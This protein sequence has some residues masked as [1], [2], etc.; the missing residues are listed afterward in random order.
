MPGP[1]SETSATQAAPTDPDTDAST[2]SPPRPAA[3]RAVAEPDPDREA[4]ARL[5]GLG[6]TLVT[7]VLETFGSADAFREAALEGDLERIGTVPGL[8]EKRAVE[9]VHAVRGTL[10]ADFLG[11]ER[12]VRVFDAVRDRI[13]ARAATTPGKRHLRLL[14]PL[15]DR[16]AREAAVQEALAAAEEVQGLDLDTARQALAKLAPLGDPRPAYEGTVTIFVDTPDDREALRDAGI[17]RWAAIASAR[18]HE[19][20][21]NTEA[22]VYAYSD[23]GSPLMEA[24]HALSV[25][26]S[27]DPA[28]VVPWSETTRFEKARTALQAA[29]TLSDLRDR[30]SPARE[31]LA[32]LDAMV[33]DKTDV[34]PRQLPTLIQD[35]YDDAIAEAETRLGELTLTG[36]DLVAALSDRAPDA[37]RQLYVDAMDKATERIRAETGLHLDAFTETVPPEIDEKA[38]RGAQRDLQG[39]G[40]VRRLEAQ[41]KAAEALVKLRAGVIEEIEDHFAFDARQALGAF[42]A[43]HRL[44][45]PEWGD[46]LRLRAALHLDHPDGE[47]VDYRL[48]TDDEGKADPVRMALLTGAN[49]GGKTTLL[50]TIAQV[51]TM[52]H[53]GLPVPAAHAT[54]PELDAVH[55]FAQKR[56]LSAGAF[57]DFLVRF[58]PLARAEGRVFVL[59]D[60]VEAMTELEAA[61]EIIAS[62]LEDLAARDAFALFVTHMGP[63]VLPL[64]P[65]DVR[66]DG[67][68]ATGLDDEDRLVVSRSPR[69]GA[70]ARSTPELILTRLSRQGPEELREAFATLADR[71]RARMDEARGMR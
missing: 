16:S 6:P 9:L 26:F 46:G 41:A 47:P 48:G 33:D 62:F 24:D 4:L 7:R 29:A 58:F 49:S 64:V 57:E 52:A 25:P 15:P 21:R 8:S 28:V 67:I 23:G 51:L 36:K 12:V 45:A 2:E 35:I 32:V 38:V 31:A 3:D 69:I 17:D 63:H 65:D 68:E 55:F 59:A 30:P 54:V 39:K 5:P 40:A 19:R 66:V 50:E 37:V 27:T 18:D 43:D 70:L 1:T 53:A 44:T 61:A 20:A 10:H 22:A 11:T 34:D 14:N 60:E 71:V 56:S 13:L 42:V